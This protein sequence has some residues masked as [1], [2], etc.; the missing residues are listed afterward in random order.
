MEFY[1][2]L[3]VLSKHFS[4][5]RDI[6]LIPIDIN[7][8][9]WYVVSLT[10]F[11][12]IFSPSNF[13]GEGNMIWKKSHFCP[14]YFL[15]NGWSL[16]WI[17]FILRSLVCWFCLGK[18]M[19]QLNWWPPN[20]LRVLCKRQAILGLGFRVQGEGLR[21]CKEVNLNICISRCWLQEALK[22]SMWVQNHWTFFISD[23]EG[24]HEIVILLMEEI[25]HQLII[26]GLSHYSEGF[27]HPRWSINSSFPFSIRQK[28]PFFVRQSGTACLESR[29]RNMPGNRILPCAW[30][31]TLFLRA[32][33]QEL[34]QFSLELITIA[35]HHFCCHIWVY[36][37]QS[38]LVYHQNLDS[39]S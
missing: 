29:S 8:W 39:S 33:R 15:K 27:I 3:V 28:W 4:I 35:S 12:N 32:K 26:C 1:K 30:A 38:V 37:W 25:L 2:T 22:L 16:W 5:K 36:K 7:K 31:L 10:F 23:L 17:I 19:D 34:A 14:R 24:F 11:L 13:F 20:S 18:G 9:R 6:L 21:S